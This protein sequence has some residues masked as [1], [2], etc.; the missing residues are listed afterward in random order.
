VNG[1]GRIRSR[2]AEG[3]LLPP[4]LTGNPEA[5]FVVLLPTA[6]SGR[7]QAR[8]ADTPYDEARAHELTAAEEADNPGVFRPGLELSSPAGPIAGR[9]RANR[10]SDRP[11]AGAVAII[12]N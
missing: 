7:A 5:I 4:N 6:T 3:P 2:S 1:S 10:R 12:G 8:S 9:P 11:A